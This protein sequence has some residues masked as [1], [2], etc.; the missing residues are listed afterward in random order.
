MAKKI[1]ATAVP[2]KIGTLYPPPHHQHTKAREKRALGDAAGLTQFGVNLTRLKPDTWS[3]LPH[4]HETEDEFVYVLEGHP[5]LVYGDTTEALSPGDSVG[6]RAG[7]EIGHCIQNNT[8]EDVVLLEVGSRNPKE[9]AFYPG[10]DFMADMSGSNAYY[11][12]DGTPV[13]DVKRRG[14]EDD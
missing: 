2:V 12:F 13:A 9:R 4:W 3:A 8:D 11:H 10:L 7:E 5:T 6:F 14:P 1:E